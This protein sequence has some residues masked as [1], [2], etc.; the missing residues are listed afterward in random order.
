V[1]PR[2]AIPARAAYLISKLLSEVIE[3]GFASIVRRTGIKAGG[4]TGTSSATMDT[5]FVAFTSRIVTAVWLGD[6]M[7]QRPLGKDDA[8]YMTVVPMWARYMAEVS[9]GHPNR[10]VPWEVPAGA[11]LHDRGDHKRGETASRPMPLLYRKHAKPTDAPTEQ[12]GAA[13]AGAAGR[14][15]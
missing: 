3:Y 10:P 11:S 2:Q 8:A 4:K 14:R 13:P 6:D 7:R 1:R 9:R 12:Q 15:G 5:S